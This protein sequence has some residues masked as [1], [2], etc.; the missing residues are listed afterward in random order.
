[1]TTAYIG[2][3]ISRV[4]GHAK[5]TGGAKYAAEYNIPG[6]AY[7]YV[8]SSTVA[9]G[10]ITRIDASDALSLPGVVQVLTHEN[11]PRLARSD[12]SWGDPL[13]SPGSPFRPLQSD[14][15]KFSAQP[16]ALVVADD[17]DL[18]RHAASL[19]R[20]EYAVEPHAT[21][22]EAER[23]HAYKPPKDRNAIPPV[24][25]PRGNAAQAFAN[26]AVQ[27]TVEYRVP[28]E[29]H[30]PMELFGT[31]VA[32]D[33]GGTLTVY[34]KT[35]GVQH[36]E[37]YLRNVFGYSKGDLRVV[38]AFVGGGFGSG[39]RPQYQVFLAVLAAHALKRSVRVS[40]TRQQMFSLVHRPATWQRV[41]LA[42]APD[43]R[44]E[45]IVHEAVYETSRFEDY[46][47]P[48]VHWSG[49][50]YQCDNVTLD[51]KVAALDVNT[52]GDMRAPGAA[53]GLFALECAMDELAVQ[54]RIDPIELR[55]KNYAEKDQNE[56]LPFSSNAL[57]ECYQQGAERFGW[58]RRNPEPRSMREGDTLIGWGMASG[59]WEAGQ[60]EAS[61]NC[62]LT[63]DGRLTVSSAT[64]DIG[65]GTYTIMTQIAADVLG[66]PLENVT[67]KLGDSSLPQAPVEGGSQ[68]ASSVGPAVKTVCEKVRDK[69]IK[70]ARKI[71]NSPLADVALDDIVLADGRI[72]SR[73][74]PSRAVSLTDAMRHGKLDVIEEEA[75]AAPS[76]RRSKYACNTHSA[77]FAE[78]R[79]DADL[80][81]IQVT[82]V[83]SAVAG[84]RILN[85][86]TARSQLL[87][88]VVWGIGMAL[89]EESVMD[90]AF[91]RFMNHSLAEYHVPVNAD[92]HEIDVI[93]VEEHDDVVNPLGAKGLGEI[94]L[95][96]VAAAIANAV[97]HATG[98]RIRELPITLDKV[99]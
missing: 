61:A 4:D 28:V 99:M 57:R 7:G 54:L 12:S 91:G 62:V 13:D 69:L 8:V 68:T 25:K 82:R 18:A 14:D 89:E 44:L 41:R 21:D 92:V 48:I 63:V 2:Q 55:L 27:L 30:N 60:A 42:A 6:L 94:G 19:V 96:G 45:S 5:V 88:G 32:R 98:K 20:V 22:L 47:E 24:P 23:S 11:A 80:G 72:H 83:V 46:N 86:K 78:V 77:V 37:G 81:T 58:A 31:T 36:V 74:D 87:G 51:Q 38:A 84:G 75:S 1:M 59:I 76:S 64:E 43:G 39:L 65:C 9:R 93:F 67:F 85:P 95:V 16:I 34:D 70:L 15:I 10:K 33:E 29:H 71:D 3:P 50:I 52:P 66:M 53:T 90:H 73:I 49:I 97:F 26:A 17:F 40:L 79:I 56:G 35:Q